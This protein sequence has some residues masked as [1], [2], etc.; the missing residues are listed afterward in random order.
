MSGRSADP[1][2][3]WT[4]RQ[5]AVALALAGLNLG[6]GA[7]VAAELRVPSNAAA[8]PAPPAPD[9]ASIAVP[10]AG[11]ASLP[12]LASLAAVIERPLFAANRRPL[13]HAAAAPAADPK[14]FSLAGITI[15]GGERAAFVRHA[16]SPAI[17]RLTEGQEIDGW[18]VRAIAADR[19]T[20]RHGA[21]EATMPLYKPANP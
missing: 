4:R 15:A 7:I 3:S 19:I 13:A 21:A 10:S 2:S 5:K 20:L 11:N 18:T 1:R 12:P 9:P 6:L 8:A 14:T 16:G 17:Q